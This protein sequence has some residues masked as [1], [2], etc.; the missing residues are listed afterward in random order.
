MARCVALTTSPGDSRLQSSQGDHM[1]AIALALAAC[2]ATACSTSAETPRT[3]TEQAPSA[4]LVMACARIGAP[5]VSDLARVIALADPIQREKRLSDISDTVSEIAAQVQQAATS[6]PATEA[7]DFAALEASLVGYSEALGAYR[8][9]AGGPYG[10][11]L[12]P[13]IE[14]LTAVAASCATVA[15][16]SDVE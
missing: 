1:K 12:G 3:A 9:A 2:L 6:A 15:L 7:D 16:E 5:P 11:A 13:V 10:P 4:G 8:Q 14:A